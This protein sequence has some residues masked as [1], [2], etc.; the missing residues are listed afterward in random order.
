MNSI[1]NEYKSGR[2]AVA[3]KTF[4]EI[5]VVRPWPLISKLTLPRFTFSERQFTNVSSSS[6]PR[7]DPISLPAQFAPKFEFRVASRFLVRKT[8]ISPRFQFGCKSSKSMRVFTKFRGTHS[9]YYYYLHSRQRQAPICKSNEG[10]I[11]LFDM[12]SFVPHSTLTI[13]DST[14]FPSTVKNPTQSQTPGSTS[15]PFQLYF[16]ITISHSAFPPSQSSK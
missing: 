11:S 6:P 12:L 3:L 7:S 1:H 13:F 4:V 5:F 8:T 16:P 14:H 2:S 9:A 15:K 10:V